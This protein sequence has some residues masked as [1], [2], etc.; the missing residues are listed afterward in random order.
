MSPWPPKSWDLQTLSLAALYFNLTLDVTRARLATAEGA[1]VTASARPNPTLD[2][3]PGIPSPYL[4]SLDFLLPIETAGKRGHRVQ[5]AQDLNRAAE[6]DLADSAWTVVMGVRLALLNYLVASRNLELLRSQEKAREDQVRI[7]ERQ[8]S[9][10]GITRVDVDVTKIQ[11][12]K[13]EVAIR[14]A[15][16]QVADSKAALAATIGIPVAGLDGADLSWPDMGIP[17]NS[18]SLSPVKIQGDA[19]LNRLDVRRSLAQYAAA[20]A[21]LKLEIARQYPN[22]NLGPGY[23]YE[24]RNNF[25]TIGLSTTLPVFNRNQGPIAEAEGRRKEAAAAFLKTQAQVI[26]KS[27]RA[28]AVYAAALKEISEA[29]SLY[30]IQETQLQVIQ[31]AIRAGAD[32][33]FSLDGA[34]IQLSVL[35]SAKL[36]ALAHA[37]RALGDLEDAVQR[38]LA[39]GEVFP[40][41]ANSPALNKNPQR[42]E[43]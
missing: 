2:F 36:D 29:Q 1:I 5:I 9:V 37:Q 7:L 14:A 33:R 26:E 40:I 18:E 4:L 38:P 8:L 25:F 21:D 20:D 24:E 43:K 35:A 30:Q 32:Y 39:P 31:Q 13:T 23:T 27:E 16:G 11:L 12:L 10:G 22:F 28:L 34:Q 6:F 42:P 19:V 3:A 17:P 15:E 41:N